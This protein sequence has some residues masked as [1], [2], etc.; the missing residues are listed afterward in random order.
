MPFY[1]HDVSTMSNFLITVTVTVTEAL[2][3]HPLPEDQGRITASICILVPVER[4]KQKWLYNYDN[5]YNWDCHRCHYHHHYKT[6]VA[7]QCHSQSHQWHIF[8][9]SQTKTAQVSHCNTILPATTFQQSDNS[10][11]F[12]KIL[13]VNNSYIYTHLK[14]PKLYTHL[15]WKL[16]INLSLL[17][18][19][20]WT[21]HNDPVA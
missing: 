19:L 3:L 13:L 17:T 15:G 20:T 16:I 6:S 5:D 11:F 2:V 9:R 4:M 8:S 10:F 7:E 21:N 1:I 14:N 12:L 18:L